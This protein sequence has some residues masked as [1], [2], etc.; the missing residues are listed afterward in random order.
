MRKLFRSF[1]AQ[2]RNLRSAPQ[3]TTLGVSEDEYYKGLFV[4]DPV[5]NAAKPNKDEAARWTEIQKFCQHIFEMED[6]N[7][8]KIIDVGCGRGWLSEKLSD[9]GVVTGIEP[10][11]S[12]I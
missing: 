9:F 7:V 6:C 12:V 10:V 4:N 3:L 1:V 2:I 11:E 8:E 5:W